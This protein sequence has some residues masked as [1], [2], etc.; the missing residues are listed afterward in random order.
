[1]HN[2]LKKAIAL[3]MSVFMIGSALPAMNVKAD[4]LW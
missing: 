1:M 3:S 2:N 4:C